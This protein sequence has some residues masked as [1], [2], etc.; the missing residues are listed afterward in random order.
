MFNPHASMGRAQVHHLAQIL[1]NPQK[2]QTTRKR[3]AHSVQLN[4]P[5]GEMMVAA[6]MGSCISMTAWFSSYGSGKSTG[7]LMI[8]VVPFL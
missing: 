3:M 4:I 6:T 2:G 7:L 8:F 5:S 1:C